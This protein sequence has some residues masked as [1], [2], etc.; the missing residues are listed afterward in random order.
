MAIKPPALL[1]VLLR[2][3]MVLRK[4]TF[5]RSLQICFSSTIFLLLVQPGLIAQTLIGGETNS[6]VLAVEVIPPT[7]ELPAIQPDLPTVAE[8]VRLILRRGERKVYVYRGDEQV[9]SYPVAVGRP[10]WETPIGT[11]EVIQMLENPGWTNPFTRE[12]VPPGPRNPLG[13]R[14]IG[15]WT[16]GR[17]Y[18]GFHGTPNRETVGRAASHGCVRMYNEDIRFLYEIVAMGTV[19]VVEQ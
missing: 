10:G 18:I 14:W 17:D 19:V 12:T 7:L 16:D 3:T 13:E 1:R 15:F 6:R 2:M 4:A 11:F 5:S 9:A 8:E